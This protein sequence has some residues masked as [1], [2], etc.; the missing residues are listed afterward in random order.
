MVATSRVVPGFKD[1]DLGEWDAAVARSGFHLVDGVGGGVVLPDEMFTF[2]V[3]PTGRSFQELDVLP[4][5]GF[6]QACVEAHRCGEVLSEIKPDLGPRL[7]KLIRRDL[8]P[9]ALARGDHQTVIGAKRFRPFPSRRPRAA[10]LSSPSSEP[11]IAEYLIPFALTRTGKPLAGYYQRGE[12]SEAWLIP[13]DVHDIVPWFEA[14]LYRWHEVNPARFPQAPDWSNQDRWRSPAE[15]AASKAL[16]DLDTEK[17]DTLAAY[18]HRGTELE[19]ELEAAQAAANGYE[20]ALLTGQGDDLVAAVRRAFEEF[21][22]DVVDVDKA[23]ARPDEL[24]E[25]LQVRD[26]DSPDWIALVEVRGYAAGAKTSDLQRIGRF[27]NRWERNN[28]RP[29]S[30]AWYVVNHDLLDDPALRVPALTSNQDDVEAFGEDMG[31]VIDTV[32]LV[33]WLERARMGDPSDVRARFRA[34]TG[35]LDPAFDAR[36]GE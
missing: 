33:G 7:V 36:P 14:A 30:A 12:R 3:V 28:G 23:V 31:L 20:R 34:S 4:G 8:V 24:L 18:A 2:R 32:E 9:V 21:G 16:T 5:P 15:R 13:D 29:P 11:L 27:R 22:F 17:E 6:V 19:A 35:R 1:L 25:D 10:E 26:P